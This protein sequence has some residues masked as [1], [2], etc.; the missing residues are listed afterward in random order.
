MRFLQRAV[1]N[2]MTAHAGVVRDEAGLTTGLAEIADIET[3]LTDLAVHP[4]LAGFADLAHAF[5]LKAEMLAARATL[6]APGSDGKPAAVTTAPTIPTSTRHC[7]S[8]SSGP[9][10]DRSPMN[11]SPTSP[12][13]SLT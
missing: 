6:E 1:R 4:D 10:P 8:T 13:T 7:R 5:D 2:T 12:S 9:D 3:R 11:P